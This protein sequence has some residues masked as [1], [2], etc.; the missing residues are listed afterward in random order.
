MQ[1]EFYT[2]QNKNGVIIENV[3][4]FTYDYI[5]GSYRIYTTDQEIIIVEENM[6]NFI[7]S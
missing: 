6:L 4:Y 2:T 3:E 7:V 1:I 5:R